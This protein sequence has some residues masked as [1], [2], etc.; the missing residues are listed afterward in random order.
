MQENLTLRFGIRNVK[1]E[2][3]KSYLFLKLSIN[4]DQKRIGLRIKVDTESW[5][6]NQQ[7]VLGK[8]N[9]AKLINQELELVKTRIRTVYNDLRFKNGNVTV[10]QVININ[11]GQS[12][13]GDTHTLLTIFDIHN[14]KATELK[15]IKYAKSTVVR[16][17]T[18]RRHV[19]EFVKSNYKTDDIA[20][21]KLNFRF[22]EDLNHYFLTVRRC[23]HNST[24][25]YI[26]CVK[27]IVKL[28]MQYEWIEKDPFINYKQSLLEVKRGHLTEDELRA[29]ESLQLETVRLEIVR[30]LF[31]FCCYTGL[32]YADAASLKPKQIVTYPDGHLWINTHRKKTDGKSHIPLFRKAE[33]ILE[34]Y[35]NNPKCDVIGT[36]LPF[37]SNASM[38]QT[39]KE[40]AIL[41]GIDKN[42]SMHLARHTFATT[43]T[44]NNDVPIETVSS[45]LGHK[46]IRATQIY[47]RILDKKIDNDMKVLR[48]KLEV[49]LND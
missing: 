10:Q 47:A 16:Y 24:V 27:S 3:N 42:I 40:I 7:C 34:K 39:L 6:Q 41:A 15:G 33:I 4:H 1:F 22:L 21:K 25:K 19:A 44:L 5:S 28:A 45:M 9:Q 14:K 30:D 8:S 36:V 18:T 13:D 46:N 31:V 32:A 11:N 26:R 29:I 2:P 49:D 35:L 48:A 17:H 37:R 12:I 20:L 43:V 38:N 23:N